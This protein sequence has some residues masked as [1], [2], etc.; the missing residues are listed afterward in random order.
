MASNTGK[1]AGGIGAI[2]L[3]VAIWKFLNGDPWI[4]WVLLGFLLGGFGF[5]FGRKD[6]E[7]DAS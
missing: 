6:G 3:G 7:A 2:F 4:V 1:G 5:F